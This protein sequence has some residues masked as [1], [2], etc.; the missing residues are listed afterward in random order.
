MSTN[1]LR[2]LKWFAWLLGFFLLLILIV[3]P[4]LTS[5]LFRFDLMPSGSTKV[6]D[7][8]VQIQAFAL[9]LF[10]FAWIFFFGSCFA[11]FLNVVAWRVPRGRSILGSSHCP[12]CNT[13]LAFRDN[14]PVFGW[15]KNGG[16]CRTCR[17]PIS[18]RYLVAEIVLGA[19]F[20]IMAVVELNGG[21]INLPFRPTDKP[22]GFENLLFDPKWDLLLV[23][24]Y[25]LILLSSLFTFALVRSEGFTVPKVL[26]AI[27][28]ILGIGSPLLWPEMSLVSWQNDY[29][30]AANIQSDWASHLT[31]TLIGGAAGLFVGR[32]LKWSLDSEDIESKTS[33]QLAGGLLVVGVF[34]GWQAVFSVAILYLL[35]NILWHLIGGRVRLLRAL[36]EP[37]VGNEFAGLLLATLIH[38]LSWR[39]Q[40]YVPFWLTP[41]ESWT[42]LLLAIVTWAALSLANK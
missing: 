40:A 22:R 9:R 23:L 32:A 28:L 25:Q 19:I 5:A 1:R 24:F 8:F 18:P 16:R 11:S 29:R 39:A 10:T 31:T 21:G 41:G 27:P 13:K 30:A 37:L 20:L 4:L 2:S 34:L 35:L 17:L 15:L 14:L 7:V 6:L 42:T 38:L 3:L 33:W 36:R 26:L 12:H